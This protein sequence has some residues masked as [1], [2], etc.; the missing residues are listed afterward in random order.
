MLILVKKKS[1]FILVA[2]VAVVGIGYFV[3]VQ[4]GSLPVP[5]V[6]LTPRATEKDFAFIEDATLRKH[7]VAQ[8]NKTAYRT[9][10]LSDAS[11]L[12]HVNEVQIKGDLWSTREIQSD[13]AKEIKHLI[14]IGDTTYLKDQSDNQWWKQT[15]KFEEE[16]TTEEGKKPEEPIDF[17][18]EFSKPN[19]T[20]K[21]L[22]KEP[23][24]N[25]TCFKYE[26]TLPESP[27]LK[28]IFWFDDRD[29][30]LRKE[31]SGF[32]EFIAITEYSYND[33]NITPP[34]STKDVPEGKSIYDYDTLTPAG[35]QIP[36]MQEIER[37]QQQ[38]G[39]PEDTNPDNSNN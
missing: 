3:L 11:G 28:R 5:G 33:I 7:L 29:Y 13:Q 27:E 20:Y 16:T 21:S 36:S 8:T 1:L 24:D 35:S 23:C 4:Q 12:T 2:I 10:T 37:I 17:K 26:Q 30:L 32:G 9:K 22:G 31:Q 19:I 14:I 39:L 15:V 18:E 6:S 34:S 25:L 38:F